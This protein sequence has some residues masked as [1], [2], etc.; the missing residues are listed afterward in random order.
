MVSGKLGAIHRF[1]PM[2]AKY[3]SDFCVE[4]VM[5]RSGR[6]QKEA[7]SCRKGCITLRHET[8][9]LEMAE[10]GYNNMSS[11]DR[12]LIISALND[13]HDEHVKF[14]ESIYGNGKAA[15]LIATVV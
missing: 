11:V 9:W 6:L 10:K 1:L 14:E 2:T 13:F 12:E 7:Y 15:E 5:T 4:F 3:A 8:G